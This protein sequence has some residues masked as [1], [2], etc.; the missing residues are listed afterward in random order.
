MPVVGVRVTVRKA[1]SAEDVTRGF[2]IS[3]LSKLVRDL[4]L[5]EAQHRVDSLDVEHFVALIEAFPRLR[6]LKVDV[7]EIWINKSTLPDSL[8]HVHA[9]DR[10]SASPTLATLE[11]LRISTLTHT[12]LPLV[13]DLLSSTP[14]I[15]KL[16]LEGYIEHH[17]NAHPPIDLPELRELSLVGVLPSLLHDLALL[18]PTSFTKIERIAYDLPDAYY[19]PTSTILQHVGQSLR[20]LEYSAE[21]RAPGDVVADLALCPVLEKLHWTHTGRLDGSILKD[22]PPKVHTLAFLSWADARQVV[23]DGEGVI[24][25][26]I[27][28]VKIHIEPGLGERSQLYHV[29]RGAVEQVCRQHGVRVVV[30]EPARPC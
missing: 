11:H 10:L 22:L 26:P 28:T 20:E 5:D 24:P 4:W 30:G 25:R 12:N 3:S 16:H 14:N 17:H 15:Q 13:L 27:K 2:Q 6:L 1:E 18:T 19:A 8:L 9:L 23:A 29:C 21:A 7:K